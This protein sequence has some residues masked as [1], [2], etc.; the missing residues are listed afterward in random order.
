MPQDISSGL[1]PSDRPGNPAALNRAGEK[2][3]NIVLKMEGICKTFGEARVLKSVDFE[4][5]KGE[6]H[7]LVGGNGAGKSTLMKIMTGVYTLDEGAIY[8][9]GE[10][11]RSPGP[12]MPRS[13]ESP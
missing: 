2:M 12:T 3:D 9:N 11:R 5:A 7:A 10:K 1:V 4:L 13:A 8:V 6:V